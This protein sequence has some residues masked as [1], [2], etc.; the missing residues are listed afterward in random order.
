MRVMNGSAKVAE[1]KHVENFFAKLAKTSASFPKIRKTNHKNR[2]ILSK[3]S[4]KLPPELIEAKID[5]SKTKWNIPQC[6]K[7]Q[8][9][10]LQTAKFLLTSKRRKKIEQ[11]LLFK[12]FFSTTAPNVNAQGHKG[13][14]SCLSRWITFSNL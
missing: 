1:V 8:G 12:R 6:L 7:L 4:R 13:A 11:E 3:I 5:F 2:V 14:F 10:V 9:F